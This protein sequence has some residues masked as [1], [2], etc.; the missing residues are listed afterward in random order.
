M[1]C[2]NDELM[3][4]ELGDE[5]MHTHTELGEAVW[6][7]RPARTARCDRRR[8]ERN[9]NDAAT[10]RYLRGANQVHRTWPWTLTDSQEVSSRPC[11]S[12]THRI[13]A[14]IAPAAVALA[15]VALHR[16]GY[17]RGGATI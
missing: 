3:S 14:L 6:K 12:R 16:R 8:P 4:V 10:G 13:I 11:G 15:G 9:E 2:T 7:S 5:P 1:L 17:P